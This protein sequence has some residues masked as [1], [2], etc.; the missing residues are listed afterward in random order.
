MFNNPSRTNMWSD[1]FHFKGSR[2]RN[3]P[4][5]ESS[6]SV[7][8]RHCKAAIISLSEIDLSVHRNLSF[9]HLRN[10]YIYLLKIGY[11][12]LEMT[13]SIL[14]LFQIMFK[15]P[16]PDTDTLS[17]DILLPHNRFDCVD[18]IQIRL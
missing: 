16:L 4:R 14:S 2:N 9:G 6:S 8:I 13:D 3:H 1:W 18:L 12:P 11:L 5:L 15:E 10:T 7:P 17:F